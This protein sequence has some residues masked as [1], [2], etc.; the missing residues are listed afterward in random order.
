M[1]CAR[2]GRYLERDETALSYK[3]LGRA[4][5]QCFCLECLG[6]RFR[7]SREQLLELI[8]HFRDAGCTLFR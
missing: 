1:N 7:L 5:P 3:L 8:L 6:K 2:C 4:S